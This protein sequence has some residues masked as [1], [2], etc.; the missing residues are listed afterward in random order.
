[1]FRIKKNKA[2]LETHVFLFQNTLVFTDSVTKKTKV[3]H[4]T[5]CDV[6]DDDGAKVDETKV[7][8]GATFTLR[9]LRFV[10]YVCLTGFHLHLTVRCAASKSTNILFIHEQIF[11]AF[12][13]QAKSRI[14]TYQITKLHVQLFLQSR[15][16]EQGGSSSG[17]LFKFQVTNTPN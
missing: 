12:N 6:V 13:Y 2:P 17:G 3:C 8:M 14:L 10:D 16:D 5:L 9:T 11:K 1:M 4:L 7:Q 15:T